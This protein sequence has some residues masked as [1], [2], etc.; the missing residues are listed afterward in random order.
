MLK[1]FLNIS[2]R[3]LKRQKANSIINVAG[4]SVGIMACIIIILYVRNE[5]SYEKWYPDADKIYRVNSIYETSGNVSKLAIGPSKVIQVSLQDIPETVYATFVFDWRVGR[6]LLI[7]HDDKSFI[8]QNVFYA[9]SSFFKVFDY[10]FLEGNQND[11]LR[12]SKSIVFTESTALKYFDSVE[13]AFNSTVKLNDSEVKITGIVADPKG[14]TALEFDMVVSTNTLFNQIDNS[15]WF[16]MNYFNYVKVKDELAAQQ[17]QDK[18][19]AY[20]QKDFGEAMEANGF[21][22]SFEIQPI[23]DMHFNTGYEADYSGVLSKQLIYSLIAIAIFILLIACINYINLST[24]KSEKRA[25]EVGIRKVLGAHRQQLVLQFFGETFL[26]VLF[27]VVLGVVLAELF[28]PFFNQM[29]NVQLSI[30][31]FEDR[32]FIPMLLGFIIVVALLSGSYPASFLSSFQPAKVLKGAF[33]VKG[34]NM[35]RR[36]LVTLQFAVSVFLITGTLILYFQLTYIQSKDIG[37]D[38]DQVVMV[39]LPD[40]N[41]RKAYSS[42]K[43]RFDNIV[44]VEAVT[45]SNNEISNV[46]SGWGAVMDGL[47][48]NVTISFRGMCGDQDFLETFGFDL[49]AGEG[50]QNKSDWDSTVYYLVNRTGIEKLGL[51]PEEAVGK[52]FGIDESMMGYISGVVEDF[53]LASLHSEIEPWAVYTGPQNYKQMLYARVDMSRIEAIKNEMAS[54]WSEF[55]PNRQFDFQYVNQAVKSLYKKDKQLGQII[56]TFT[57]LAIVIGCLGLF[58]L[59]S[60]L[61]EKRTKEIGI[62]KVLGADVSK[63]VLLLSKEY[64]WIILVSNLIGWPIAYYAMD[65][66]LQSFAFR[67]D[68]HPAYFLAAGLTTVFVALITVSYQSLKAANSNPTEALRSE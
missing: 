30:E 24:A 22:M 20:I 36:V 46:L 16:P 3:N 61:A 35:F 44:G 66:W 43:S 49:I 17:Y 52:R 54:I 45:A 1:N 31:L 25:K 34:G 60:Y 56:L 15:R 68:I 64:L 50:F 23:T 39:K 47:P 51:T 40:S 2:I 11:A 6:E 19:N 65:K 38:Q 13:E 27:S 32:Q 57:I 63:I 5:L 42:I 58:G 67:I 10:R 7:K 29:A 9:D 48:E 37:Y 28:L 4:L 59:A 21:K 53:H 18:L 55:V 12:E 41:S 14:Q 8:E 33:Q 26:V 62:R